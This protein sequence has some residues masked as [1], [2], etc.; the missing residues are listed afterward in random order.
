MLFEFLKLLMPKQYWKFS[1]DRVKKPIMVYLEFFYFCY[2]ILLFFSRYWLVGL[3]IIIVSLITAYQ[4]SE[5]VFDKTKFDKR[6]K[7]YLFADGVVSIIFMLIIILKE[8]I[9]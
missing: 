7:K 2:I 9:N 5:D 4:L 1:L 8:L 3:S 6:I